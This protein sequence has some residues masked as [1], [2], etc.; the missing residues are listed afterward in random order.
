MI[1]PRLKQQIKA[2]KLLQKAIAEELGI[3]PQNFTNKLRRGTFNKL[4]IERMNQ[5]LEI[6]PK[7]ILKNEQFN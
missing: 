5:L 6:K 7:G 4:E 1:I 2:K 3:S